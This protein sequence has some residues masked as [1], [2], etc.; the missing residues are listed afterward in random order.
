MVS[1][2]QERWV[3]IGFDL[4]FGDSSSVNI[5][6]DGV[7]VSSYCPDRTAQMKE[8]KNAVARVKLTK[9]RRKTTSISQGAKEM[10]D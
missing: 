8:I 9:I 4:F 10:G 3:F 2:G 1:D 7:Q 6:I 5:R